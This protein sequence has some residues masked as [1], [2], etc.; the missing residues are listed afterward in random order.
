MSI[1]KHPLLTYVLEDNY[2]LNGMFY[3]VNDDASYIRNAQFRYI[4]A[5]F[6]TLQER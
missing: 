1:R 5:S 6:L 2:S 3:T 4:L